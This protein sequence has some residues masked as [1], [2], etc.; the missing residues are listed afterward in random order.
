M[1][2]DDSEFQEAMTALIGRLSVASADIAVKGSAIIQRA[3]MAH[4]KVVSGTLRRSWKTEQ[5]TSGIA[6]GVFAAFVGPTA[7]YARRQELGFKG[8]DSRGR[9]F[10][11]DPGWPYV[12]PA[13][14]EARPLV[15]QLAKSAYADALRI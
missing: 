14:R 13:L 11:N 1:P 5:L 10:H 12:K 15:T 8:P 3:G 6:D 2:V 7:V 9:V 4:T